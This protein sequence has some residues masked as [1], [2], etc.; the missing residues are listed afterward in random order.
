[1]ETQI[2]DINTGEAWACRFK[3]QTFVDPKTGV[4]VEE[5]NLAVGM[6]HK[7][8]P[9]MYEG[10]G[11]IQVRDNDTK[12]VQLL[13]TVSQI[14]FKVKFEDCWDVDTVEWINPPAEAEIEA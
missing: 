14:T 13:D 3:V 1:M 10:I 4:A 5:K 7:G 8:I 12:I 6:P 9:G 2:E 11:L